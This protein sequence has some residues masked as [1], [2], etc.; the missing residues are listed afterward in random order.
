MKAKRIEIKEGNVSIPICRYADG[1]FCVDTLV[2]KSGSE[3]RASLDAA[4][5]E[6]RKLIAQIASGRAQERMTLAEV[7]DY[8]LAKNKVAPFGMSLLSAVEEWIAGRGKTQRIISKTV[9][10]VVE[11]FLTSKSGPA[12]LPLRARQA[13]PA[14][15]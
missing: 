11:E 4:K 9:A 10:E 13:L 5:I 2:G 15:K 7:E 3:S 6:A 8:R 14:A 12:T 1:R